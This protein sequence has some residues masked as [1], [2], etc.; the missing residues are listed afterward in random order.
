MTEINNTNEKSQEN[1][2]E[3]RLEKILIKHNIASAVAVVAASKGIK[4]TPPGVD[5][6]F[7]AIVVA[8]EDAYKY[9][10]WKV[11]RYDLSIINEIAKYRERSLWNSKSSD[12]N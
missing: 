9:T 6:S 10:I 1:L 2:Q 7:D 11:D 3:Q 5:N 4:P 12:P 8:V